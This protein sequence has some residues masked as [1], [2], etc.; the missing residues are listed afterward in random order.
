MPAWARLVCAGLLLGGVSAPAL[1]R[2][3]GPP[4][5]LYPPPLKAAPGHG[6]A[7]CPSHRGLEAF[8]ASSGRAALEAAGSYDRRSLETDLDNSDPAW[9]PDVRV[10]WRSGRPQS[11]LVNHTVVGSVPATR[12][13]FAA[14]LAPACGD[15][16]LERSL[17]VTIGPRQSGR[18]PH[19]VACNSQLFFI[20]RDGRALIYYLY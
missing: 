7:L 20:D 5:A 14:F 15:W 12:S 10:M 18:G 13:G 6:L 17:V 9:W 19:C 3:S 4:S 16:T 11:G 1:A 2:T 8:T